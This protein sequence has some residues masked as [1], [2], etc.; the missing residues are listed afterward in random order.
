MGAAVEERG[1]V[2]VIMG[3]GC[4]E[5]DMRLCFRGWALDEENLLDR[6]VEDE[7]A[8]EAAMSVSESGCTS[9]MPWSSCCGRAK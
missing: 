2:G 1:L 8:A 3:R 6:T 4:E 9:G 5:R 7:A